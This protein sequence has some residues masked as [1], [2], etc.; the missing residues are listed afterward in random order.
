MIDKKHF[1]HKHLQGGKYI[2]D[3]SV[4]DSVVNF[5]EKHIKHTKGPLSGKP[6]ILEQWQKEDI[7]C[8]LFGVKDK[9]GLRR[10]KFGYF[11]IPKKN[12]KSPL[13][14]AIVLVMLIFDKDEGAEVYSAA[15]TRDQAK[16]VFGDACKMAKK[17]DFIK[18]KLTVMQHAIIYGN[19]SY[20]AL[21]ADIG[22]NDGINANLVVFD[23][24]HRQPNRLLYDVLVG[25]M[26]AKE[27]PMFLM[28]TTAGDNFNS[29]CYEQHDYAIKV[30]DGVIKDER[31]LTVIYAADAKDDPFIESTW[32]KANPNY[33]ISVRKDFI[34]EQADKARQNAAYLNTFLRL[35]L[36]IWTNVSEVWITDEIW[37]NCEK[38]LKKE[39]L[40]GEVCYGGLDLSSKSDLTAF[41]LCF[42]PNEGRSYYPDKYILF[43]YSWLPKEKS[44]D[45]ADKNNTNYIQWLKDGWIEETQGNVI[46]YDYIQERIEQECAIYDVQNIA[47]DPYNSTQIVGKLEEKGLPMYSH[48]QG[49]VSMNFPTLE[50]EVKVSRG[51]LVHDSNPVMR[52]QVSNGVL[53]YNTAGNLCKVTKNVPNQKIDNLVS[54]IMA[55]GLSLVPEHSGGS[56]LDDSEPIYIDL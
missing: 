52:W 23:E 24:L 48:R 45:S 25:S 7:I 9:N 49:D 37:Q 31:Y 50:F 29:I 1:I 15:S 33:G 39:L 35:H 36:N 54:S 8:P 26:A 11:E 20:K 12:G 40:K 22:A 34:K 3:A 28:I 10:Y 44:K 51:E 2:Y 56:Y 27:Q 16:I 43:N 55:L 41:S 6:F 14:S 42:P 53:K 38:Q 18:S 19:K 17:D 30:R 46:D 21:S 32:K 13:L 4:A 47:Y 5:I